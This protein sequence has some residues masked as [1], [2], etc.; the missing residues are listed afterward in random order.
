MDAFT[1]LFVRRVCVW[2]NG[3]FFSSCLSSFFQTGPFLSSDILL[4]FVFFFFFFVRVFLSW[5]LSYQGLS[6]L[7]FLVLLCCSSSQIH[8]AFRLVPSVLIISALS[9]AYMFEVG[10]QLYGELHREL[11]LRSLSEA[12][13]EGFSPVSSAVSFYGKKSSNLF[14][15]DHLLHPSQSPFPSK[16]GQGWISR[17]T[18]SSSLRQGWLHHDRDREN[19]SDREEKNTNSPFTFSMSNSP[20]TEKG[21]SS[22]EEK[23]TLRQFL[24]TSHGSSIDDKDLKRKRRRSLASEQTTDVV[25]T[26]RTS[27]TS[28]RFLRLLKHME[29]KCDSFRFSGSWLTGEKN[30]GKGGVYTEKE[31]KREVGR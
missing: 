7:F 13:G 29:E 19:T 14:D 15:S 16:D 31:R 11:T 23:D 26:S 21:R 2:V 3:A 6:H 12:R 10:E 18:Q 4:F 20:E 24:Q 9:L 5:S 27:T 1:L 25:T 30:R 8:F 22:Q 28:D 17:R